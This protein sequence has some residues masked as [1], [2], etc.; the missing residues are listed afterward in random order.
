MK[1]VEATCLLKG[2]YTLVTN[3]TNHHFNPT[4]NS[5]MAT[6]GSGDVLSG[7]LA[8]L[9]GQGLH[10]LQK[11]GTIA[12]YIHGLAGDLAKKKLS[13]YSMI[14]S[15]IISHLPY[16]INDFVLYEK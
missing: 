5:G 3:G 10:D 6:A 11:A 16:A 15:D 14:A 9:I 12:A 4:G 13:S 8:A 1:D 2:K 7:I